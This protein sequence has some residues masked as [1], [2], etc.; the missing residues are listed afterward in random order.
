[1]AFPH[2]VSLVAEMLVQPTI[3]LSALEGAAVI[4]LISLSMTK[5]DRQGTKR[6]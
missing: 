4:Q 5:E 6:G 1:M 2:S 3:T